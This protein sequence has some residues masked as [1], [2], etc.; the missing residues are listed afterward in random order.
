M[1]ELPEPDRDAICFAHLWIGGFSEALALGK[2][3][4]AVST[5]LSNVVRHFTLSVC[6][7]T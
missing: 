1:V 5:Q 3:L 6:L 4:S 7:R 2:K